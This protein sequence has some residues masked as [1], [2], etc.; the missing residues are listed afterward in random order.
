[1]KISYQWLREYVEID[2]LTPEQVGALLTDAGVP[3]EEFTPLNLGVKGVVIGHVLETRQHENADKLRVCTIDA[4]TGEHLQIVCGAPNVA[5]GQKV[6]VAVIGAELPGDF[7]IKRAKLRGVESQGMLC[8]AKEIGLDVKLLPKDQTEGLYLL[9]SDAPIGTEITEYLY[10]NDTVLELELTPNRSDLLNYR[11]VAYEVAALLGREVKLQ[12][13]HRPQGTG[14]ASVTVQIDS[15]NCSKYSAQVIRGV[16]IAESPLWLQAKL[17][18]VGVRPINNVVDATNFVMFEMGQPLHAFDLSKVADQTIIVRQAVDGEKH[19]TLDGVERSLDDSM[20]VIADPQK[21]IG[22]AG[23]MGGENSEVDQATRDI[24]LESAYFDPATTRKTGKTLGLNSE[25]QKRFEKGM[26]DQGMVTNALLR[27]AELIVELAGGEISA[28]PVE[29]V[30]R[31]AE[32][33]TL[34]LRTERVNKLLGTEIAEEEMVAILRRLGFEVSDV[35]VEGTYQV[36]APT[37]RPDMVREADL[38]EEIARVYGYD[39][40]PVTLPEGSLVQGQLSPIQKLRRST[41]ELLI[42]SGMTEVVTYSLIN[43]SNFEKLGLATAGYEKQLK[44]MHPLSEDRNSLRTHMLPSLVE[45]VQYNRNRRENDLAIFEIGKVFIPHEIDTELPQEHFCVAGLV[46]GSFSPIGVGEKARPVDFFTAKGIVENLLIGLGIT[47]VSYERTELPGMHPGRTARI[48][49]GE[50]TLGFVG[51]LHPEAEEAAELAPTYYFELDVERLL[52][53]KH[54]ATTITASL[55]KFP[56]MERDIAVLVDLDVPAGKLLDTIYATGG[57]LLVNARIFDFYQGA[58]VPEGKK[59]IAYSLQYRSSERTL[60]DEEVTA[61][62]DK[63]LEALK[64]LY[65]AELRA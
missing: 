25:A 15:E 20:L 6:P 2:D 9:P 48:F 42:H 23:V 7:K 17:L 26:I 61:V 41:R 47:G 54:G 44:L 10:L 14:S 45:V 39:K 21:V 3:V 51:G 38:I 29:V 53:A 58:Q 34:S 35:K 52:A 28:H 36:T 11:G 30:K 37:R 49:Q 1:M 55:P 46:T 13:E 62:H 56:S 63:V 16:T 31:A 12:E 24:V 40:I 19:V 18:S 57:E 4:G 59:S 27:A 64:E 5:P 65:N 8:S 60:T 50:M 43:I 33:T 32:P 22:L